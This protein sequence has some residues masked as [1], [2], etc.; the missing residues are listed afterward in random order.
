MLFLSSELQFIMGKTT[1]ERMQA[2]K[3]RLNND[4]V[5]RFSFFLLIYY[6]CIMDISANT[7]ILIDDILKDNNYSK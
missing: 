4:P 2:D 6:Y 1:K 7:N 5:K 3:A